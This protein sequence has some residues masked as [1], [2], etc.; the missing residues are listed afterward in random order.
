MQ[1][2]SIKVFQHR[3]AQAV[4]VERAALWAAR[5][6]VFRSR[7]SSVGRVC[8]YG[9]RDQ[10]TYLDPSFSTPSRSTSVGRVYGLRDQECLDRERTVTYAWKHSFMHLVM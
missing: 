1:L 8:R 9:L 2:E 4:W 6:R 10:E 3:V 5:P 7:T